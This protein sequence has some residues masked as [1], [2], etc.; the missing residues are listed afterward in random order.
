MKIVDAAARA[1]EAL[2]GG[3][4]TPR[5]IYEEIVRLELYKFG[6]RNPISVLSGTMREKTEGSP[7]LKGEA[8]FVSQSQGTYQ[9]R[10][11]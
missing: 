11:S 9:I 2:G 1:L 6:A 4:A 3:P 7:R 8:M 10:T 5:Q